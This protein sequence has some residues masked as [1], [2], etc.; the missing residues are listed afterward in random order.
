[1]RHFA[2]EL[3]WL[4]DG[5][6]WKAVIMGED[7]KHRVIGE[8]TQIHSFAF[9]NGI[10][11]V[12]V[13]SATMTREIARKWVQAWFNG[14]FHMVSESPH[15][16]HQTKARNPDDLYRSSNWRNRARP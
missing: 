16:S 14:W 7:D 8:P 9:T 2:L 13:Y 12:H 15:L 5:D 4:E 3:Y 10:V 1:M 11:H 6:K